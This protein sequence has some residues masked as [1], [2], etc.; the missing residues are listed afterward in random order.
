MRFSRVSAI[1]A[2]AAALIVPAGVVAANPALA[3]SPT[4]T[5][6]IDVASS[7]SA[8][9]VGHTQVTLSGKLVETADETVGVPGEIA[10]IWYN[11]ASPGMDVARVTTGAGG[12]FTFSMTLTEG[13]IFVVTFPGDS[14]YAGAAEVL[15]PIHAMGEPTRITLSPQPKSLVWDGTTLRFT[16]KVEVE[17]SDGGWQPMADMNVDIEE[18]SIYWTG[19]ARMASTRTKADGTFS[20]DAVGYSGGTWV[21]WAYTGTPDP[22]SLYLK[23]TSAPDVVHL[24]YRTAISGGVSVKSAAHRT[25]AIAGNVTALEASRGSAPQWEGV[26]GLTVSYYYRILPSAT[27]IKVGSAKTG[28]DVGLFESTLKVRPGHL[29]WQ[30]RV[31]RQGVRGDVY[32]AATLSPHDIIIKP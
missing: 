31:A 4:P 24:Q 9:S 17:A 26:P 23:S 8:I 20:V 10:D 11:T 15:L 12:A 19:H 16:G 1:L 6:I 13:N 30:I 7:P 32:L 27:W 22:D 5:S 25:V 21:A 14:S 29:R 28:S 2:L 18:D 3:S